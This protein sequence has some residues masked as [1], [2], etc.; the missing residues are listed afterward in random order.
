VLSEASAVGAGRAYF[1]RGRLR[2]ACVI[3]LA[4]M[5]VELVLKVRLGHRP[6]ECCH[7]N[8]LLCNILRRVDQRINTQPG[9]TV[10]LC[11]IRYPTLNRDAF[12]LWAMTNRKWR[13]RRI[14]RHQI[15]QIYA[16]LHS[17]TVAHEVLGDCDAGHDCTMHL[18]QHEFHPNL[19]SVGSAI[20]R[21]E[22]GKERFPQDTALR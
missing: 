21:W 18:I 15:Y 13:T 12:T 10:P 7:R 4:F 2:L 16:A 5:T 3:V 17:A 14:K 11:E 22:I 8:D 6:A 9:H 1:R 19:G 20:R